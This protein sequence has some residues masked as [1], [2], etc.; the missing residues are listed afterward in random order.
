MLSSKKL[1]VG[2]DFK[3]SKL[4]KTSPWATT[5]GK[6]SGPVLL[7]WAKSL[8][9][10]WKRLPKSARR[11]ATKKDAEDRLEMCGL[12]AFLDLRPCLACHGLMGNCNHCTTSASAQVPMLGVCARWFW[13]AFQT[14]RLCLTRRGCPES[15]VL[16][17]AVSWSSRPR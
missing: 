14:L 13:P 2:F 15:R 7:L 11:T 6:V 8:S 3:T 16:T 5:F 10:A 9:A 1:H 4:P 17:R 12:A